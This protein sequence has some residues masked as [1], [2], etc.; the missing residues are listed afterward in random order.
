MKRDPLI[1]GTASVIVLAFTVSLLNIYV[2]PDVFFKANIEYNTQSE[3]LL[4]LIYKTENIGV[5]SRLFEN[6][7]TSYL[8]YDAPEK[9][10]VNLSLIIE[11]ID[12][13]IS[14]VYDFPAFMP[15]RMTLQYNGTIAGVTNTS[16]QYEDYIENVFD[17]G[18][19]GNYLSYLNNITDE[20]DS[21]SKFENLDVTDY[22]IEDANDMLFTIFQDENRR[23]DFVIYQYVSFTESRGLF[24]KYEIY[25]ERVIFIDV[26]GSIIFFISSEAEWEKPLLL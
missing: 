9:A 15:R 23:P 24:N 18:N 16:T 20:Y 5:N 14:A 19:G 13:K 2:F 25:F 10:I 22:T 4:E 7:N 6:M 26:N 17:N 3:T 12:Y 11:S 21:F 1:I 8:I